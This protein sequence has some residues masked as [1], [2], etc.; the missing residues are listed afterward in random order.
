MMRAHKA[1]DIRKILA[2]VLSA[3]LVVSLV[4]SMAFA[5]SGADDPGTIETSDQDISNAPVQAGSDGIDVGLIAQSVQDAQNEDGLVAQAANPTEGSIGNCTWAVDSSGKLTIAPKPNTDGQLPNLNYSFHSNPSGAEENTPWLK[6]GVRDRI[7]SVE[8]KAGVKGNETMQGL[9]YNCKN[10]TS[11]DLT[12]LDTSRVVRL[13]GMFDGCTGLKSYVVPNWNLTKAR[14]MTFMFYGCTGLQTLDLSKV[15]TSNIQLMDYMFQGCSALKTIKLDGFK[16]KSAKGMSYMFSGCSSLASVNLSSFDVSQVADMRYMFENCSSLSSIDLSKFNT[17]SLTNM[18][19]MFYGCRSAKSIDISGFRVSTGV[20]RG[21]SLFAGCN[22][23]QRVSVGA[24]FTFAGSN[25]YST[26]LPTGNWLSSNTNKTYTATEIAQSRNYVA[27]TYVK[28]T[29]SSV[30]PTITY[31]NNSTWSRGSMGGAAFRSSAEKLTFVRV[32]VDGSVV[33]RSN[34]DLGDESTTL[35]TLKPAYLETLR[36]GAHTIDIVSS[37]GT[38]SAKF[39]IDSNTPGSTVQGATT[40]LRLY[41]PYSGEHLFTSDANEK[42]TLVRLGWR[43]EGEAW[44]APSSGPNVYRLYNPY[45]GDHH[46]T[47]DSNEYSQLQKIG[48]KGEGVGWHSDASKRRPIYR[49]YNPYMQS[50]YHHYTTDSNERNVLTSGN[51][52]RYEGEGWYGL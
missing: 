52:W 21:P 25:S 6:T 45:S 34:Y 1:V 31:G 41:N 16:T 23:L 30:K 47:M 50:Y 32:Q 9:F 51:G 39:T 11:V 17:Q 27:D 38:A 2:V 29:P 36:D 48:W 22:A 8:V 28:Y 49:L 37:V 4:P 46:Y 43:Y 14:Q 44:K 19:D 42:N 35:V 3:M 7:R 5:V 33:S 24:G 18:R 15:D 40:M 12:R 20:D 26:H 13:D 10:L